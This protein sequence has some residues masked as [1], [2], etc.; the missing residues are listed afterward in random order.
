MQTTHSELSP[1][2]AAAAAGGGALETGGA[3]FKD[4][5]PSA[6]SDSSSI[7]FVKVGLQFGSCAVQAVISL[8]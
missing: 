8:R 1:T 6:S 3:E 2:L 7:T 5:S 4:V